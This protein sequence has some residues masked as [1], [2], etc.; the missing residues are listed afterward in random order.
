MPDKKEF[1]FSAAETVQMQNDILK[2]KAA[3]L[4]QECEIT[5][6]KAEKNQFVGMVAHDLRN[7]LGVILAFSDF[8]SDE[9]KDVLTDLQKDFLSRIHNSAKF[10]LKLIED[11][12]DLSQLD[13]GLLFPGNDM[14][15]VVSLVSK[16]IENIKVLAEIKN[17]SL[18][19]NQS[20]ADIYLRG[21]AER[22]EQVFNILLSNAVKFSPEGTVISVQTDRVGSNVCVRITDRGLGIAPED[23]DKIFVPFGKMARKGSDGVKGTGLG[24]AIASKIIGCHKGEITVESEK[25]KGSSFMVSLPL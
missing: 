5:R 3:L 25:G 6:L 22:L 17:I 14:L 4:A 21:D 11:L 10:M 8:F 12:M 18:T 19:S 20:E 9:T 24:L 13:N 7:P 15:D 16:C 1:S 23:L 2:L